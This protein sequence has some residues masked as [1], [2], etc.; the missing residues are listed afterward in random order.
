MRANGDTSSAAWVLQRYV[1]PPMLRLGAYKFHLR[2]HV[3]AVGDLD[4]WVHDD[5]VALCAAAPY[6]GASTADT[7][8]HATNLCARKRREKKET[9][10]TKE[11]AREREEGGCR[12]ARG[13]VR[14]RPSPDVERR[15]DAHH[16]GDV[17]DANPFR[18]TRGGCGSVSRRAGTRGRRARILPDGGVFRTLRFGFPTRR[19]RRRASPRGQLRSEPRGV[20]GE[21]QGHVR[22]NDRGYPRR[23]ALPEVRRAR[24]F[25][26]DDVDETTAETT[27]RGGFELVARTPPRFEG[28]VDGAVGRRKLAALVSVAGAIAR[29]EPRGDESSNGK[30]RRR[31]VAFALGGSRGAVGA[32]RALERAGWR[33]ES[34]VR[35]APECAFQWAPHGS[36]RWDRVME[37][38]GGEMTNGFATKEA[39]ATT[40]NHH[41]ARGSHQKGRRLFC[42][43][44]RE[45][46]RVRV[47]VETRARFRARRRR[48]AARRAS[49]RVARG[50]LGG[51]GGGGEARRRGRRRSRRRRRQGKVWVSPPSET[52]SR[53]TRRRSTCV[54]N[55]TESGRRE[56]R[57]SK[58]RSN[59]RAVSSPREGPRRIRSR[60]RRRRRTPR[61]IRNRSRRRRRTPRRIRSRIRRWRRT[62]SSP[63]SN[64][65]IRG[66]RAFGGDAGDARVRGGSRVTAIDRRAASKKM[67]HVKVISFVI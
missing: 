41:F 12:D 22:A 60:S 65:S 23:R 19:K 26:K 24:G 16:P 48:E 42:R 30:P 38:T 62:P 5:I 18:D 51:G 46:V 17:R 64:S 47:G 53:C 13:A 66:I 8:A 27:R 39:F 57:D 63:R 14:V 44:S 28:D 2:A 15:F 35:D 67:P 33:V 29:G 9:A 58:T 56:R 10:E 59:R 40:A 50:S 25:R 6:R 1:E 61:R 36:I 31:R 43:R 49:S 54:G 45:T 7:R 3:L 55:Q 37:E 20:R 34:A 32:R 21:T 52:V 11:A 4:A